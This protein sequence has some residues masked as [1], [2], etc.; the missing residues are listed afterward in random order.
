MRLLNMVEN[1]GLIPNHEFGFR[2]R[3]STI[4]QTH[5]LVQ[6]TNEAFENKQYCSV[7]FLD[8]SQA[9]D[10][11]WHT[12]LLFKLRAFPPLNYFTLLKSY[13]YIRHFLVKVE[14]EYSEPFPVKAG[15]PEG[16]SS[17]TTVIPATH[18]RP[19]N[20]NRIYIR[21]IC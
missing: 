10:K 21:K 15:V 4:E 20:P 17:G 19:A 5:R 16:Q 3:H 6:R 11:I 1:N 14:S 13:L 9:S 8:I 12:G 18:C 2:E 7:A